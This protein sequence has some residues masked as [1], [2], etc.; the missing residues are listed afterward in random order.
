MVAIDKTHEP[1]AAQLDAALL[2]TFIAV[3]ECASFTAAAKRLHKTQS[4]ISLRV[5]KLETALGVSLLHRDGGE[6]RPSAPGEAFLAYARRIVQLQA[7]AVSVVGRPQRQGVIRVGAPEDYAQRWLPR[8]LDR[9]RERHP[10][11]R[12]DVHCEM[13]MRLIERLARGELDVVLAV[14][15]ATHSRGEHLGRVK[16][17]WAASPQLRLD[18]EALVP[19]ALFGEGCV[20]RERALNALAGLGRP[21]RI[22]Y[23]SQSPTGIAIAIDRGLAVTVVD[24]RTKPPAWAVLGEAQG[25]PELP[26]ADVEVHRS[27]TI[28][29][30]AV[31]DLIGLLRGT[32]SATPEMR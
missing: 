9:L 27:P 22:V 26:D 3:V 32:F 21:W 1:S 24:D 6:V 14:R 15:H 18:R 2:H 19:L 11:V 5:R 20:F 17:C 25:L 7:E 29:H 23:T 4:T 8:V 31:D 10:D 30:P 28:A 13:S 16:V 12:P